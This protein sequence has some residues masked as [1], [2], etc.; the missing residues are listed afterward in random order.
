MAMDMGA[1]LS[2]YRERA[3]LTQEEAAEKLGISR[4]TLI[5]YENGEERVPMS[6]FVKMSAIYDFDVFEIAGVEDSVHSTMLDYD[7]S[8]YYL[9]KAH[10]RYAVYNEYKAAAEFMPTEHCAEDA[11]KRFRQY[12]SSVIQVVPDDIREI[13]MKEF[14]SDNDFDIFKNVLK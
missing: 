6:V 11:Q 12:L 7:I 3:A 4:S 13:V 5:R 9:F 8:I 14:N 1:K 10:A 2:F